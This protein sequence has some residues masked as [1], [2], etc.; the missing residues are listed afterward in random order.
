MSMSEMMLALA[1]MRLR[2]KPFVD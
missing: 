1:L 2:M